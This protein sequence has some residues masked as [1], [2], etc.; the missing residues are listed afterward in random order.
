MA[1]QDD[2]GLKEFYDQ[3]F[4]FPLYKDEEKEIYKAIGAGSILAGMSWN[5]LK[6]WRDIKAMGQR[7]KKKKIEGNLVGEGLK[8]GGV[9][10]F[11]SDGS[12]KYAIK[13]VTGELF[14]EEAL[15]AAL[16][17]VRNEAVLTIQ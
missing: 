3:H 8:T 2:E 14:D 17:S 7:L 15:L 6:V 12:P 9:V 10:V 5:P 11:G 4:P 13:E 1:L 16:A